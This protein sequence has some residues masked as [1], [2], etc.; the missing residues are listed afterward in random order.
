MYV[1][2]INGW[3]SCSCRADKNPQ[4]HVPVQEYSENLTEITKLLA[5]AGVSADRVI[6]I[7]PPPLHEA[8]WEKE[9]ILKG[10]DHALFTC[11]SVIIVTFQAAKIDDLL[12]CCFQDALSIGTTLWRGSTPRRVCRL[13]VS[14]EQTSWISGLSCKRTDR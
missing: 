14:V 12:H 9:C 10:R 3:M 4:Q 2:V 7:T 13:L 1:C 8:A 5:S 6:F 11:Q